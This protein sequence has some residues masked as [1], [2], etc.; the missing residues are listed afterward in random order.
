MSLTPFYHEGF[1]EVDGEKLHLV[2]D[3]YAI[4]CI[5]SVVG[6][7]MS[8]L[9]RKTTEWPDSV[10]V[11]VLWGMLRR[12]H[13]GITLDQAAGVGLGSN[14]REVGLVMFDVLFRAFPPAKEDEDKPVGPPERRGASKPS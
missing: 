11:K 4:D 2:C 7:N 5:E 13:E 8:D 12:K 3:F 9:V 14:G 6:E 1:V 10:A